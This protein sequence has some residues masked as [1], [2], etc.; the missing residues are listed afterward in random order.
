MI[1]LLESE[2]KCKENGKYERINSYVV[3]VRMSGE[4][5]LEDQKV[6]RYGSNEN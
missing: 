6:G 1:T 2:E 3:S 4:N 5:V